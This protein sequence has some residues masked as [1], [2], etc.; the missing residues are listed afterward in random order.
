MDNNEYDR[1]V[2]VLVKEALDAAGVTITRAANETGIPYATLHRKLNPNTGRV[3]PFN[4]GE[5]HTIALLLGCTEASF[6]PE[7]AA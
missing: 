1:R 3:T 6:L 2:G 4:A 7:V 5:L